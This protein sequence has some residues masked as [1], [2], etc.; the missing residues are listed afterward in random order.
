MYKLITA[1]LFFLFTI[2]SAAQAA[3]EFGEM[4][5]SEL[6]QIYKYYG[7]DGERGYLML[8]NYRY[9]PLLLK[10]LPTD[11]A[12][13][14]TIDE[15]KQHALFIKILA[16]L[17]MTINQKIADQR[18]L[19]EQI[20]RDFTTNH[21]LSKAQT[22]YVEKQAQT[23]D[24]F[25]RLQG[26][27]RYNLLL[28]ELLVRVDEI[29]PSFLIAAAAIETDWGNSRLAAEGNALYRQL[30]WHTSQGLK[31]QDETTETDYR[32]KS[33]PTLYAAMEEFALKLNSH[34]N[35]AH[36]RKFRKQLRLRNSPLQGTTFAYTLFGNSALKNYAG[37]LEY[38]IAY[39][40]LNIIDK[41]HLDDKMIVEQLP[42]NLSKHLRSKL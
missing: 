14:K 26:Y 9:Q 22:A 30:S 38:T 21:E 3:L 17:A 33:Y 10:R 37:I 12:A 40:E 13:L 41:S 31:P 15:E 36:M 2:T 18:R 20:N 28:K 25:T 1:V 42:A 32:I 39:Y 35:F 19:L 29:P 5:V 23:Y 11:F 34:I 4:S 8:D 27:Q 6:E 16:P 24:I 7:Y